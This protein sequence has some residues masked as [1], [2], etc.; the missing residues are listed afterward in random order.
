M[1]FIPKA[2]LLLDNQYRLFKTKDC[3]PILMSGKVLT[4]KKDRMVAA[5]GETVCKLYSNGLPAHMWDVIS[6][7]FYHIA[8]PGLMGVIFDEEQDIGYMMQQCHTLHTNPRDVEALRQ[9][10]LIAYQ[11]TGYVFHDFLPCNIGVYRSGPTILDLE[12][13]SKKTTS[14]DKRYESLLS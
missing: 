10:L 13:V 8:A 12:S 1:D 3:L 2:M 14:K 5:Y 11:K 9:Q 6:S 4:K 7:G